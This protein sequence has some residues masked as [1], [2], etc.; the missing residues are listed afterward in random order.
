MK[1]APELREWLSEQLLENFRR[2]HSDCVDTWRQLEGKAQ[3]LITVGGVFLAA[4]FAFARDLQALGLIEK[5]LLVTSLLLLV[6][7]VFF[8]LMVFRIVAVEKAPLGAFMREGV[9]DI[10]RRQ[11]SDIRAYVERFM[12]EQA[13]QWNQA[14]QGLVAANET[15]A[16]WV[17]RSQT[18]LVVAI[19]ATAAFGVYRIVA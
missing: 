12:E 10:T 1:D 17:W 4:T 6:G 18:C 13:T 8:G 9:R 14:I 19:I 3:V 2:E 16:D 7:V 15:K 11:D 5:L